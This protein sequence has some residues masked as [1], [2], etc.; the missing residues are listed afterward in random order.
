MTNFKSDIQYLLDKADIVEYASATVLYLGFADIGDPDTDAAAWAVCRITYSTADS[1]TYPRT[2]T[3]EWGDGAKL[4]GL[5]W[6]DRATHT[7][8]FPL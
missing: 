7:Y 4:P 5:T 2:I 1:S 3:T 8:K 6:D